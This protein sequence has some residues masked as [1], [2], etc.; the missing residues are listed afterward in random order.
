MVPFLHR[1]RLR[2]VQGLE[3]FAIRKIDNLHAVRGGNCFYKQA[4]AELIVRKAREVVSIH[5]KSHDGWPCLHDPVGDWENGHFIH[6]ATLI[7]VGTGTV[8]RIFGHRC[9]EG[10]TEN[11]SPKVKQKIRAFLE[12]GDLDRTLQN[13]IVRNGGLCE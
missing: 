1:F 6:L 9:H 12:T 13:H 2:K 7:D 8:K 10:E 4:A 5:Y 3:D 11:I